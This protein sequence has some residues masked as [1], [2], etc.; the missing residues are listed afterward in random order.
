MTKL[1]QDILNEIKKYTK[2][3][4]K[5]DENII[6]ISYQGLLE[7]GRGVALSFAGQLTMT[8]QQNLEIEKLVKKEFG[9]IIAKYDG[10]FEDYAID[11]KYYITLILN[12]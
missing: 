8:G 9:H 4:V 7:G 5:Q 3:K 6:T 11:N 1:Q 2:G 10:A 12:T